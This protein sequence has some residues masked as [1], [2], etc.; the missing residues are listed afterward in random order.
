L[1]AMVTWSN[2]WCAVIV[3]SYDRVPHSFCAILEL[4]LECLDDVIRIVLTQ[5][6]CTVPGE[7]STWGPM[8]PSP[9]TAI[10]CVSSDNGC[11]NAPRTPYDE[12][13]S[14]GPAEAGAVVS[15]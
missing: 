6:H 1:I 8:L 12:L 14:Q 10:G 7:M 3:Q 11:R 2:F 13:V 9:R 15:C 5:M 4:E